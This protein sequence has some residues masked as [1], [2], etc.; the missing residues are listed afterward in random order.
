M[1]NPE[2][3]KLDDLVRRL[4]E[5]VLVRDLLSR[6]GTDVHELDAGI[7]RMGEELGRAALGR[8]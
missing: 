1:S 8:R 5:L 7:V 3:G 4:K 6:R 2:L